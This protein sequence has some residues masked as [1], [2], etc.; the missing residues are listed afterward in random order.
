MPKFEDFET[1]QYYYQ[2][3]REYGIQHINWG[4][5]FKILT[6]EL[7]NESLE[8]FTSSIPELKKTSFDE[9]HIC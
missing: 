6:K 9:L 7:I 2:R 8:D 1:E 4:S 3:L 5:Q